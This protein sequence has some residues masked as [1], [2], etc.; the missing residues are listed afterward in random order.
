MILLQYCF[1]L[2]QLVI[3]NVFYLD[4]V[5]QFLYRRQPEA[6]CPAL[7]TKRLIYL[8]HKPFCIFFFFFFW[9]DSL[10][11]SL[12]HQCS[13]FFTLI[14]FLHMNR[15]MVSGVKYFLPGNI[16]SSKS[17]R[18]AFRYQITLLVHIRLHR[19][20]I[21]PDDF[22]FEAKYIYM[23]LFSCFAATGYMYYIDNTNKFSSEYMSEILNVL[24]VAE[25]REI[26]SVLKQVSIYRFHL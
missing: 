26:M 3:V 17:N 2:Q 22:K 11:L 21:V 13:I 20:Q 9:D 7:H 12:F 14:L 16:G 24:N 6:F 18:T 4:R 19:L 1:R 10:F 15:T 25:L 5:V 8:E 23:L